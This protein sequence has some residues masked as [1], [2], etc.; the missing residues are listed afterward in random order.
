MKNLEKWIADYVVELNLCPFAANTLKKDK[1]KVMTADFTDVASIELLFTSFLGESPEK[2]D[3]YFITSEQLT[4]WDDFLFYFHFL[5]DLTRQIKPF[6][7]VK[8]VGFHPNYKHAEIEEDQLHFSNKAPWPII[9]F[10]HTSDVEERTKFIDIEEILEHNEK[11][12]LGFTVEEL[13]KK[14]NEC[15][16]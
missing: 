14:L 4:T 13:N 15:K 1:W 2:T 12:L 6:Q 9:Q 11:T 7:A 10:L 16:G 3:S 5:G 8:I